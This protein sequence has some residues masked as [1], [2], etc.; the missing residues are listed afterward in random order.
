M[1]Q[2]VTT[3]EDKTLT[4][5]PQFDGHYDHWSELMENLLRAN[6]LWNMVAG[7]FV[8]PSEKEAIKA[9]KK[10]LEEM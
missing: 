3:S 9:Q 5:I 7:G 1:I 8:E 4:K 10:E 2:N 6:G